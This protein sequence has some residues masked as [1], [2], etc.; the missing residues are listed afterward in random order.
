MYMSETPAEGLW[1][2][3]EKSKQKEALAA[4]ERIYMKAI[5]DAIFDYQ[6]LDELNAK[7]YFQEQRWQKVINVSTILS[8]VICCLGLFGLSHLSAYQLTREIGIRKVL[9]ASLT[10]MATL[11]SKDFLKLVLLSCLLAFPIAWLVMSNW[12]H[13][14]AYRVNFSWW[15][16]LSAGIAAIVIAAVTI[17]F[18]SIKAAMANPVISLRSE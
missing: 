16:F 11:L 14:Y 2:K 6:F 17:S 15:I 4:L 5:P 8:L 3:V 18:Q 7:Q 1:V 10:S 13:N 9:G 12:L